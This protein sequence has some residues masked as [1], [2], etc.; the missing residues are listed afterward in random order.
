MPTDLLHPSDC[1]E[2]ASNALGEIRACYGDLQTFV[3]GVFDRLD[4]VVEELRSE[5]SA[6]EWTKWQAEQSTL[7]VQIDRLALLASDMAQSIAEQKHLTVERERAQ[8]EKAEA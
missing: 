2:Q 1:Q 3:A 5:M 7:Q 8:P 6:H 4:A